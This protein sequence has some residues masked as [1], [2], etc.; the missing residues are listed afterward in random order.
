LEIR[1]ID[2]PAAADALETLYLSRLLELGEYDIGIFD[3]KLV[4]FN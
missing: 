4:K 3:I 1:A 2:A